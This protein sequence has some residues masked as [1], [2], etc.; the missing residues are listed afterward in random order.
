MLAE[1]LK[2]IDLPHDHGELR[3]IKVEAV[4]EVI[5]VGSKG[6]GIFPRATTEG[7]VRD[8]VDIAT[9]LV[10]ES[11]VI[12]IVGSLVGRKDVGKKEGLLACSTRRP[13]DRC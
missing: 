12:E 7:E 13:R 4:R 1:G 10:S 9:E 8:L 2:C 11:L 3:A 5:N 6:L